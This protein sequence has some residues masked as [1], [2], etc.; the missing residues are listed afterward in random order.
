MT[1]TIILYVHQMAME[2][3]SNSKDKCLK[4]ILHFRNFQKKIKR[5]A[6]LFDTPE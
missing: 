3:K 1:K 6:H 2:Q 5:A 4:E